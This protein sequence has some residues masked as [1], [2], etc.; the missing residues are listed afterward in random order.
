MGSVSIATTKWASAS[1][2]GVLAVALSRICRLFRAPAFQVPGL[3]RSVSCNT[4]RLAMA[5][6]QLRGLN[7]NFNV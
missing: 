3:L 5:L 1:E 4:S 6:H 7:V 2:S